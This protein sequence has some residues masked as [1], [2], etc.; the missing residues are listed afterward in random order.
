[1]ILQ[2]EL[3]SLKIHPHLPTNLK[4][5]PPVPACLR[6]RAAVRAMPDDLRLVGLPR[7]VEHTG[8]AVAEVRWLAVTAGV[9]RGHHRS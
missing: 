6:I 3:T 5:N 1:M 7:H 8:R 4:I 9:L 2:H